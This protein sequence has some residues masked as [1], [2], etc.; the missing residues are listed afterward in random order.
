LLMFSASCQ[1]AAAWDLEVAGPNLQAAQQQHNIKTPLGILLKGLCT[2][3][4]RRLAALWVGCGFKCFCCSFFCLLCS[5]ASAP[6][7]VACR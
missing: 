2:P 6:V 5:C 4:H 1:Q 3:S 7:L